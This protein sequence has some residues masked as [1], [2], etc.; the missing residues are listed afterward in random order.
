MTKTVLKNQIINK[1][2]IITGPTSGIGYATALELTKYGIVILLGRNQRKLNQLQKAIEHKGYKAITV[3]CDISDIKSVRNAAEEIMQLG[4]SIS[5][6]LNNAGIMPS[7]A[8]KNAQGWDLTYA[9]NHL[10][11]FAL[12]EALAPHLPDGANV[13]F[14]ASAIEDPER[15]PAKVM[16]MKGGRYI[17]T[18][19]SARGEWEA[20][21]TKM[22]G[23]DAYATSKQCILAAT[24]Y[25]ARE[26][27]RLHFNAVEPGITRGTG[28]GSGN[29]PPIVHFIFGYLMSIIPPF[30]KYSS[31]PEK[32][33]KVITKVL[34]DTSGKTGI[35][36]DEKGEPMLGSTLVLDHNFQDRVVSETRAFLSKFR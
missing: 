13:V 27:K 3:L 19:A 8:S 34:T 18:E 12:T 25:F 30:S 29:V 10:G 14:I 20:G 9:T 1:A 31:T 4:L 2:Y 5:G 28:L 33:A 11:A 36:Y 24:L 23:V 32:S 16:G 15:K 35:Y 7:K 6:L 17:S 22:A 26:N 21:G